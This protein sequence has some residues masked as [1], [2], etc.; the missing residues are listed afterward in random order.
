MTV[1]MHLCA[2]RCVVQIKEQFDATSW[3]KKAIQTEKR[4]N[5][6]DFDRFKCMLLRKQKSKVV[7][8]EVHKLLAPHRAKQT[9]AQ[10]AASAAKKQK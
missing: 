1:F 7:G 2:F 5:L 8:M 6:T 9:A 4:K 3:G 10:K